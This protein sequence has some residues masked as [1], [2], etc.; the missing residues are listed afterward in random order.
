M[1]SS[2]ALDGHQVVIEIPDGAAEGA[3]SEEGLH[4]AGVVRVLVERDGGGAAEVV[5]SELA[6]DADAFAQAIE[7]DA[8]GVGI[9]CLEGEAVGAVA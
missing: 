8:E 4:V 3:V 5:R 1:S 6:R 2:V 7:G 9:V